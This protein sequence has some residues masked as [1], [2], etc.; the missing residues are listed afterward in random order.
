MKPQRRNVLIGAIVIII[1][2]AVYFLYT[3]YSWSY[4][5]GKILDETGVQGGL[6]VHLG[7]GNGKLTAGLHANDRY[8]VHGLARDKESVEK[9][10][11]YIHSRDLYGLVTVERLDDNNL[12][13]TDNL[14][15]LLVAENLDGVSMDEVMRVL[16]PN[17]IA[18]IKEEGEWQ[19]REKDHPANTDEWTH[20]LHGPSN[21]AVA[22]DTE[23]EPP[24]HLQWKGGPMFSRSHELI[25]SIRAM[26]SS[27]GRIFY[28]IDEAPLGIKDPQVPSQWRLVA[29]DAYNGVILWKRP[30]KGDS[31]VAYT[32]SMSR[33]HWVGYKGSPS[34][35]EDD[36]TPGV[37]PECLVADGDRV[38]VTLGKNSTVSVLNA[39]TGQTVQELSHT[40]GT[41]KI[42]YH[43]DNLVL[44]REPG[45]SN[46]GDI[47]QTIDPS[48][49]EVLWE[50][51]EDNLVPRSLAARQNRVFY[52]NTHG[53]VAVDLESGEELWNSR[54]QESEALQW[55]SSGKMVVTDEVVL[56]Q[57][58]RH[59]VALSPENGELLWK[60]PGAQ[61][62]NPPLF[63]AGGLV[64]SGEPEFLNRK[65]KNSGPLDASKAP[66][67]HIYRAGGGSY[68]SLPQ[69]RNTIVE[70]E[71]YEPLNGKVK[72]TIKVKNLLSPGHHFR[73]Y[74]G[75]AT[76]RY[77]LWNKRGIEFMDLTGDNHMR[78]DWLRGMCHLG[79]MPANGMIYMPPHQCFC[80]PAS[81]I[82]GF[83]AVVGR[84]DSLRWSSE[85][86]AH[87]HEQGPAYETELKEPASRSDQWPMYRHDSKRSGSLPSGVQKDLT[88]QWEKD[89]GGELTQ[90]VVADGNLYI[91]QIN[92]H[93]IHCLD[94]RSG[95]IQW[96]RKEVGVRDQRESGL[97]PDL[98]PGFTSFR[99]L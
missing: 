64:W 33:N 58:T 49:G 29:R 7:C 88:R 87:P 24:R 75:K 23:V 65:I 9:A 43:R 96:R 91:S 12:P 21:N 32:K 41:R 62:N 16:A 67:D 86:A 70:K 14:V 35:K 3:Q 53:I 44:H 89:L 19:T 27:G 28:V 71:G 50:I 97:L 60:G 61:S 84:L 63:V 74:P 5:A 30:V 18:C 13:Y 46:Q 26:V 36:G 78:H 69:I 98:L 52:H 82:D 68:Y 85:H 20:H 25:P 92:A 95:N 90:P 73:C 37:K 10:R 99:C 79:F 48:S 42:L 22:R 72:R 81:K 38:Y 83:N 31:T 59:L 56:F 17:G 6:V 94:A 77:L 80:Y 4:R 34:T 76:S 45:R 40:E 47:I 54:Q 1:A 39:S 66:Y 11:D 2:A 51:S 57:S 15:N 93:R 8:L 55:G